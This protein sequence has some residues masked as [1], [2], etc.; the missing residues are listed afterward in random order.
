MPRTPLD[1]RTFLRGA[2][3]CIGLP[4]LDA[5]LPVGLG[6]ERKA[7]ALR[8][9]RL[10]L[11]SRPLGYHSPFFFPNQ[12]GMDY[13]PSRYLAP[14]VEFRREFTVF[15]GLAHRGY[16]AGHHAEVALFTGVA[17][18]G[19]R[20]MNAIRNSVSLD[21][22]VAER[23]GSATRFP[24]L[25]LGGGGTGAL[26]WNRKGVRVPAEERATQVF[27]QLFIDG[28]PQEVAREIERLRTGR[29][30][31]DGVREQARALAGTLGP[32]D[33]ERLDLL[34]ASIRDAEQRLVQDQAWVQKPKPKVPLPPP[35]EDFLEDQRKL[36]R[37]RQWLD[38]VHLALQTDSTRV[39]TL[40][41]W[42]YGPV[43]L[44]GVAIGHHDAT[45]HGQDEAKIRQL[46]LIEEAEMGSFAEF[47]GKLKRTDDGGV[48][49]LDRT[50]VLYASNLGNGS[51]H[52]CD[53]LPVILAG[54]GF[55]HAGHVAYDRQNNTPL[56]NLFVRML[57]QLD[58]EL[59]AFG[60]STGTLSEV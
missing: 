45:H 39:L 27:K 4:L 43:N 53:N 52:T 1:R 54:G 8:A 6:A 15:S 38:L 13:A 24:Y 32:T 55:R 10:L 31:L 37:D 16:P 60:S 12:S 22:E 34:L 9:K 21:Q 47:L 28:T 33:R 46:A 26:S 29:S 41:L 49:L 23:I 14:L 56:S 57:Q 51:A 36:D 19:V 7:E 5:M 20:D 40:W 44:P 3:V 11:I 42:S 48:P 58:I 30:I 59:D 25:T 18:D 35:A 17:A 2:G 50:A